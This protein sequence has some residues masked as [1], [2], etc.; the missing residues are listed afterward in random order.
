[1]DY[2]HHYNLGGILRKI[3]CMR[4]D[5]GSCLALADMYYNAKGVEQNMTRAHELYLR[6]AALYSPE[7][8]NGSGDACFNLARLYKDG[9]GV[10]MDPSRA[11]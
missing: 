11:D 7:C 6:S 1:M 4:G 5:A 10:E 9:K 8:T 3:A 2:N